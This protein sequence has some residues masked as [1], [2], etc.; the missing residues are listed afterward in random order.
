MASR[1]G[2][3]SVVSRSIETSSERRTFTKSIIARSVIAVSRE[4]RSQAT[5]V[6]INFYQPVNRVKTDCRN[7]PF[8][9][10]YFPRLPLNLIPTYPQYPKLPPL[11]ITTNTHPSTHPI[12]NPPPTSPIASTAPQTCASGSAKSA[13]PPATASSSLDSSYTNSP[14]AENRESSILTLT[15]LP[16]GSSASVGTVWRG[17]RRTKCGG[18]SE[19]PI[20]RGKVLGIWA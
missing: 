19:A 9:T 2:R 15:R 8:S 14:N 5:A 4:S 11:P 1:P 12:Y 20:F 10:P 17:R 16:S 3:S 7:A 6:D 18:S 13:G